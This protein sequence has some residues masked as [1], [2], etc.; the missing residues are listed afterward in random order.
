MDRYDRTLAYLYLPD[1]RMVNEHV[2][3]EL[4]DKREAEKK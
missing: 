1:G 2:L 4:L 3:R